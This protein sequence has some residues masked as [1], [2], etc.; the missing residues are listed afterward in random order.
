M[1]DLEN[2]VMVSTAKS[3]NLRNLESWHE[4]L[5]AATWNLETTSAFS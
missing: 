4:K 1:D 2:N 5:T 3:F